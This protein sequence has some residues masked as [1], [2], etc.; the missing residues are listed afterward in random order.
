MLRLLISLLIRLFF[1]RPAGIAPGQKACG[2]TDAQERLE[3][4]Y[5]IAH[6][7]RYRRPPP[8]APKPVFEANN[9]FDFSL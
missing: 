2:I 4:A 9:D 3:E 7:K 5:C 6:G 8:S 1:R